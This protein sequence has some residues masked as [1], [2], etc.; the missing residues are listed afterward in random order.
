MSPKPATQ[1]LS[2]SHSHGHLR[3][4]HWLNFNVV[5]SMPGMVTSIVAAML[6][7]CDMTVRSC[8]PPVGQLNTR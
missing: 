6:G 1:L 8:T 7:L 3:L 4:R 2:Y 5:M